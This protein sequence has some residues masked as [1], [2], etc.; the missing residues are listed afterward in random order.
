MPL[1]ITAFQTPANLSQNVMDKMTETQMLDRSFDLGTKFGRFD[2][3]YEH[4]VI[5]TKE[6]G[7]IWIQFDIIG[8]HITGQNSGSY[9]LDKQGQKMVQV[10]LREQMDMDTKG[11]YIEDIQVVE[12]KDRVQPL[13]MKCGRLAM[14]QTE[15]N[16]LE[17]DY[18]GQF[19]TLTRSWHLF[20]WK[21]SRF[22]SRNGLVLIVLAIVAGAVTLVR[23][24]V[25]RQQ[26][27]VVVDDAEAALLA[28]EYEEAP[29]E[30]DDVPEVDEKNAKA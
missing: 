5:G 9:L 27:R 17:W 16:P 15:F 3:Q 11:L 7:K 1:D 6:A 8:A 30:Y 22:I 14:V 28:P 24:R 25:A 12:R 18:Y 26:K 13:K 21:T 29:P 2:L 20:L 23:R 10:L 19:G 4:T